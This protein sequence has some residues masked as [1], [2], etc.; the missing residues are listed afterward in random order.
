[1]YHTIEIVADVVA[2]LERSRKLP[3]EQL[4]LKRGTRLQAQIKPYVMERPEG[5]VEVADLFLEDGSAARGV[6]F[7]CFSFVD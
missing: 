6:L 1:M 7:G 3:L 2:D 5:P 4:A